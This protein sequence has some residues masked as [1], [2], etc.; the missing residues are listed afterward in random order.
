MSWF[1]EPQEKLPADTFA[2][3]PVRKYGKTVMMHCQV[4][5]PRGVVGRPLC[6]RGAGHG[7]LHR[8]LTGA[9][10]DNETQEGTEG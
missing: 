5:A 1:W 6:D 9:F 2:P 8:T 3:T 7:G 10:W 4:R